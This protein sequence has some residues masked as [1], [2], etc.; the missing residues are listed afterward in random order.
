[1]SF[2]PCVYPVIPVTASFIAGM[3]TRGTKRMGL[4]LSL[5]YVLG[6]SL[7]Y[8]T[9]AVLAAITGKFF[10][11]VQS[12]PFSM[13][14]VAVVLGMFAFVMFEKIHLPV[15]GFHVQNRIK[16]KNIFTV[17]LFGMASGLII[18]P[19]TAPVLGALLLYVSSKQ[20]IF[21]SIILMF[22]F[23]YGVGTS[24]ILVGTFSGLLG[25]LPKSGIWMVRVKQFCGVILLLASLYFFVQACIRI[26]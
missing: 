8:C 21:R 23:S 19:C 12:S 17:I 26:F 15:L 4:V 25:S 16:T 3:N 5:L 7:T 22:I 14:F 9:L 2:T 13:F 24:L 6:I 20:D 1:M 18:G 10:G 11:Q